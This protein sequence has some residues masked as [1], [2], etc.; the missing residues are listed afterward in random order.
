[1]IAR[2][3]RTRIDMAR[4]EEWDRVVRERSTPM[5][6]LQ[7]GMLAVFHARDGDEWLTV[8]IWRDA[9]AVDALDSSQHYTTTAADL[10]ATGMVL[11]DP[12]TEAFDVSSFDASELVAALGP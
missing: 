8:T 3:W 10:L 9:P 11:R 6:R 7:D 2:T 5:F 4:L 1:M 12:V